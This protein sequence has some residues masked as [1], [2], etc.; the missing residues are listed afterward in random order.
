ME[1]KSQNDHVAQYSSYDIV[2]EVIHDKGIALSD[3]GDAVGIKFRNPKRQLNEKILTAG[4]WFEICEFL[5][6]TTDSIFVGYHSKA[7]I[8]SM[9]KAS[10]LHSYFQ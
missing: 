9:I 6:I 8:E 2:M 10:S 4:Q 5:E 3:L 7:S 1:P